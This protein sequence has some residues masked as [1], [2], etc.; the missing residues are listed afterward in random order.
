MTIGRHGPLTADEARKEAKKL[1]GA[2]AKGDDPA[3]DRAAIRKE[4]TVGELI[5]LYEREGYFVQRGVRQ[6]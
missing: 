4:M 6:G 1:L 3:G 5:D 2:V